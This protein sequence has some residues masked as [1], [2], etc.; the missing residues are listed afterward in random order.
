MT[1]GPRGHRHLPMPLWLQGAVV[2]LQAA[3]LS[4]VI[5]LVPVFA[6]WFAGGFA[7]RSAASAARL[8]GQ[9]WLLLHGTPL[10]VATGG[11]PGVFSLIPLG[12]TLIPLLL[13]WRGGRRLARASYTDQLWQ[14]VVGALGVY[15]LAGMGTAYICSTPEVSVPTPLGALV[16]LVPVTVGLLGGVRRE[17]GSWSRLV[18]VDPADAVARSSQRMRWAGSYLWSVLRAAGL[19]VLAVLAAGAVLLAVALAVNWADIITIVEALHPGSVGAAALTVGQLA[20]LPNLAIWTA[21]Y[22]SG[23][24]FAVGAGTTVSPFTT[25]VGALPA[26]PVL[27]A[28]PTTTPTFALLTLLIPVIAGMLAGWWFLR[29]AENHFDDWLALRIKPRWISATLSTLV[30]GVAAGAVAGLLMGLAAWL[31]GGGIG[32]GRLTE[33]G[34]HLG[35][36]A[37]LTAAEV[38]VG[39]VLGYV[40]GPWL[41]RQPPLEELPAR[42]PVSAT[43]DVD[44]LQPTS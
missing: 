33:L 37:A 3:L 7:D 4:A 19:A 31:S 9:V 34:P 43:V 5:V 16:P 13:A 17:A 30:L 26:V 10:T 40:V 6:A 41:E 21:S 20:V 23:A 39:V 42:E 25:D 38:A 24:G 2:F 44:D 1:L 36:T 15:A 28:I 29:E 22:S 12:G 18:G 35:L 11:D 27:G 14:A 8:A 32:L